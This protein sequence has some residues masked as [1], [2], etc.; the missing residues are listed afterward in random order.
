[1]NQIIGIGV[2][3][4][5]AL[6]AYFL[7][8]VLKAEVIPLVLF[9]FSGFVAIVDYSRRYFYTVGLLSY[10]FITLTNVVIA[11]DQALYPVIIF[12][13][14]SMI[15]MIMFGLYIGMKA[16]CWYENREVKKG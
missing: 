9:A 12:Y 2:A 14:L 11:R 3:C 15:A 10:P 1:M 7:H 16:K 4:V 13:E 5:S 6:M 8:T